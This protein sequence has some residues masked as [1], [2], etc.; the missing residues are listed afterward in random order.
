MIVNTSAK[1]RRKER[2]LG[3]TPFQGLIAPTELERRTA[4]DADDYA[5]AGLHNY[6]K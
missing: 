3:I 6:A 2:L 5:L 4:S 1:V